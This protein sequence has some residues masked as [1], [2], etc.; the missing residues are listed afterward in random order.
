M[1]GHQICRKFPSACNLLS[2]LKTIKKIL[3]SKILATFLIFQNR[4]EQV[5][6]ENLTKADQRRLVLQP[7]AWKNLEIL[8]K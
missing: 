5:C 7:R 3:K 4:E 2:I 8:I 6:S 1:Q